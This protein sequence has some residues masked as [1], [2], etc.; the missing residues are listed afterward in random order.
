TLVRTQYRAG[1]V[2]YLSL[3]TSE[4]QYDTARIAYIQAATRQLADTAA[5]YVALGGGGEAAAP[6]SPHPGSPQES[7]Q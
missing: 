7:R 3:L 5:L 2:D 4:V 6:P 1:A